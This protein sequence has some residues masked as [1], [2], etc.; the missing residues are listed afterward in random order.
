[1]SVP[2]QPIT[3][4]R[5]VAHDGVVF[6]R[7]T[8]ERLRSIMPFLDFIIYCVDVKICQPKTVEGRAY[9]LK[10][11]Y[12][13]LSENHIDSL[14]ADDDALVKFRDHLF[15]R[16]AVNRS[17]D[18]QARRRTVNGDL[19]NV[20]KYYAWL[21]KNH[22]EYR[23]KRLLGLSACQI[24]SSLLEE[25]G[26]RGTGPD[27]QRYPV[28]FRNAGERSKHRLGWVPDEEHR[29]QLT[30]YFYDTFPTNLAARNCLIFELAWSVGWRRGSILS[31]VAE[32]FACEVVLAGDQARDILIRPPKQKFGYSNTFP[33]E[34]RQGLRVLHYI[35]HERAEIIQRTNSTFSE[36][37]LNVR[38]G[39][40]LTEGA[41]SGIFNTARHSLGWPAGA[42]L[43]GWRR[44][45]TNKYIER[46]IDARIE[47]GLDTGG[48]T[49]AMSVATALGHESLDSQAA[50][51]RDAQRRIRGSATFRDKVEHARLSDENAAL[52]AEIAQLRTLMK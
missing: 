1:M 31:L 22:P 32:Q 19:R 11:W 7:L 27:G 20:Y 38:T 48:E 37:F 35:E 43:H 29:A 47:L 21:Q 13:F 24:T 10:M 39:E 3:L 12:Q 44:G 18:K 6:W 8:D 16:V 33:V 28:T 36:V 45:F 17:G 26:A 42:G 34:R 46:E 25:R 41:V 5:D 9:S 50:Y 23:C 15:K 2:R 51:V 52:R 30:A 4:Q 40:P 14:D 49:I